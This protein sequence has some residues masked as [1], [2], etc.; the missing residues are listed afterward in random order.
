MMAGPHPH[1]LELL[2]Y[3]EDEL[4]NDRRREIGAHVEQ[5]S[6][7]GETIGEL[8]GARAALKAVPTLELPADRRAEIDAEVR[9]SAPPWR[10]R[11]RPGRLVAVVAPVAALA[12][13][14][15]GVMTVTTGRDDP[16]TGGEAAAPQA[17]LQ[18]E[19]R[20]GGEA[21]E[22]AEEAPEASAGQAPLSAVGPVASVAG[23]SADVASLLAEEGFDARVVNGRVVVRGAEP[24]AVFR[25]L[26]G[27]PRGPVRV[28]VE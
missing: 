27:R 24:P 22:G 13:V 28:L 6:A 1:D 9:G 14:V 7:C 19:D 11:L 4:P 2:D 15:V 8:A 26:A 16:G 25:A 18:A 5:C 3:V 20:A 10:A 17:E 21:D 12:A 23:P